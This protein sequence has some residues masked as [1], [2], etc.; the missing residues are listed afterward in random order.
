MRLFTL[1]HE[2]GVR[3]CMCLV[4][5]TVVTDWRCMRVGERGRYRVAQQS[6]M[7]CTTWAL[8]TLWWAI[9]PRHGSGWHKL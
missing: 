4:A 3:V 7:G 1:A 2:V 6:G 8:H 5:C 9:G